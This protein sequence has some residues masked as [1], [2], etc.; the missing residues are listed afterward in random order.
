LAICAKKERKLNQFTSEILWNPVI[1]LQ[2]N[3]FL[4]VSIRD[5]CIVFVG[6]NC[7]F[8]SCKLSF[9]S[10]FFVLP[11]TWS[12]QTPICAIYLSELIFVNLSIAI[13]SSISFNNLGSSKVTEADRHLLQD[14][15]QALWCHSCN[16]LQTLVF[17]EWCQLY[18]KFWIYCHFPVFVPCQTLSVSL[19]F[20]SLI[21]SSLFNKVCLLCSV[22]SL[23]AATLYQGYP[24][25]NHKFWNS[26]W[27]CQTL[28]VSLDFPSLIVSSLFNKVC[29]LFMGEGQG[30]TSEG[31]H[32]SCFYFAMF[33]LFR[34]W[35]SS[36]C[37]WSIY[38]SV[39]TLLSVNRWKT[40]NAMA[41]RNRTK[42]QTTVYKT[43]T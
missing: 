21:V 36:T 4:I 6:I 7:W 39:H 18:N 19:D 16:L 38:L 9:P 34:W 1:Y 2:W 14:C 24:D 5:K 37:I 42:G 43:C 22:A 13:L 27:T 28:S 25:R 11:F 33:L 20:P 30:T 40:D 8:D 31:K 41:K 35:T 23:L 17:K 29:L 10:V 3:I 12:K 32:C 15:L 26:V